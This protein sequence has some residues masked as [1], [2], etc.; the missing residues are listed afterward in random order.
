MSAG[1]EEQYIEAGFP[2]KICST[3][4]N[5][6]D[7]SENKLKVNILDIGCGKG[8]LGQ[9][10]KEEGYLRTTGMDC[11]NNLLELAKDKNSYYQ[12]ERRV[13]GQKDTVITDEM[14]EKY[15]FVSAASILNNDGYDIKIFKNMVECC[16]TNGFIVFATKLDFHQKNQ[17]EPEIKELEDTGFWQFTSEHSFYRYDK[18][19]DKVGKFSTKLVKILCYQKIDHSKW[20]AEQAVIKKMKEDA[21]LKQKLKE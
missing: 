5:K 1:Y 6:L 4:I 11:S 18:L 7:N 10:L 15:D 19:C 8:Y 12:L 20:L 9:Y 21:L 16:K 14:K 3:I 17:Y 2:P 13:F